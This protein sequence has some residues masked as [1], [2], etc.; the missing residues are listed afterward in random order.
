MIPWVHLDTAAVPGGGELKLMRRGDEFSI[1][2]GSTTLMNSRM[3]GSEIVLA[4]LA[5]DRLGGRRNC[6]MLIGGYGMGFTLRA[7]LSGLGPDARV[8]VAELV[9]AVVEW[10][11]GAMAELTAGCLDDSR[12]CIRNVDVGE[13]IASARSRFDAILLDVDNGPDGLSR[14]ANDRL[15]DRRG[16]EAARKALR[17]K[18]LLAV[19]SA[20]PNKAFR[21]R[22]G[23]AG[24]A[25]E[26]VEARGNKGRGARHVIWI[27]TSAESSVGKI[28]S[29]PN[30]IS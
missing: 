17:P 22:L 6:S 30:P 20:G 12:S 13:V 7:A 14:S 5:C 26:E 23:Q 9:P 2:A 27:A 11:R 21:R 24:F 10:A 4:E 18:G 3:S 29:D 1:M 16:L 8:L 28:R 19:W 25:V 15:Y